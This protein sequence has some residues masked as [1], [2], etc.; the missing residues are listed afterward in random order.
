M[1]I[2]V[3]AE[4]GLSE[5]LPEYPF[6]NRSGL[7]D[8][9]VAQ[10]PG[11]REVARQLQSWINNARAATSRS[12]MFDRGAYA[13]PDNFYNELAAARHAMAYDDVV[14]GVAEITEAFAFQGLKF[15]GASRDDSD[16]FNQIAKLVNLDGV[17]RSM[18]RE[19]YAAA[20]FVVAVTWGQ[21]TFKVRGKT[22]DGNKRKKTYD[23]WCPTKLTLLDSSKVVPVDFGPLGSDKLAWSATSGQTD[24]LAQVKA[25]LVIDP[26]MD[27][28]FVRQYHP[29]ATE[30]TELVA[31]GVRPDNLLLMNPDMVWRHTYTKA[32]YE[33]FANVRLKPIFRLL[34]MKQQLIQADRATLI[35]AANY[36]LLIR[37]GTDDIPA[38]GA[39][40][41]HLKE[42]YQYIAKLPVI[43]SDHRLTVD[44]IAPKDDFV[45][46]PDRYDLLD[47]RILARLLGTLS[48]SGRGQRNETNVTVSKAVARMMENRRHMMK[49][50]LEAKLVDAIIEHPKNKG[51]FDDPDS[52]PKIVF[53]PR[54]I[55]LDV[56]AAIVQAVIGLRTQREVSRETVL[57]FF[58]LDQ[59][60]EAKRM[61]W[62]GELYDPIFKSIMPFSGVQPGDGDDGGDGN[63]PQS[64]GA[65]GGRPVGGGTETQNPGRVR[66]K[67]SRGN[68]STGDD[69]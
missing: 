49:R 58:G 3:E 9:V 60:T 41:Q 29:D 20:Q 33:R 59:A 30:K 48:L 34:D 51:K 10:D 53:T 18:W 5:H 14:S 8:A 28:F 44:I 4:S 24:H 26:E 50:T 43:I 16:V 21:R 11:L 6:I 1:S 54:N 12:S 37:K 66:P 19:E 31:L 35:G 57:E 46:K 40:I 63:S 15:E 67:T 64:D 36:I 17:V 2:D 61:A 47:T 38:D 68:P 13:P 69:Q 62:E 55:A 7:S 52:P 65:K 23:I 56:N 25:G 22:E 42:N 27:S 45:L 39:E 32:D